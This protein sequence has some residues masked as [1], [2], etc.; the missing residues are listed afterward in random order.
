MVPT[1]VLDTLIVSTVA[2]SMA[3][4]TTAAT[5]KKFGILHFGK[6]KDEDKDS[7]KP[8]PL[9]G[10]LSTLVG[11]LKETQLT[12]LQRH[13]QHERSF[14]VGEKKFEALQKD[15][16]DLKEGVGILMD[17]SGGRPVSWHT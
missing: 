17:R 2:V 8:C 1:E 10:E 12:N 13:E 3:F 9:H 16:G 14:A 7:S 6:K 4:I 5:L 15:V 11:K